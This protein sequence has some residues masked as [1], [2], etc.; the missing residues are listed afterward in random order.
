MQSLPE[1]VQKLKEKVNNPK[2]VLINK[3]DLQEPIYIYRKDIK[4]IKQISKCLFQINYSNPIYV[5]TCLN[6]GFSFETTKY[7]KLKLKKMYDSIYYD[8]EI[9]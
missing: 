3:S 9:V 1:I 7:E 2:N 5:S 6:T 8:I 4:S